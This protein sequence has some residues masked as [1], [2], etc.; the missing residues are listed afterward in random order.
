M[1]K[2]S[3]RHIYKEVD[4][5]NLYIY[6]DTF[7]YICKMFC[8]HIHIHP[9]STSYFLISDWLY[10]SK[11]DI[12]HIFIYGS[13][14]KPSLVVFTAGNAV[15]S[16]FNSSQALKQFQTPPEVTQKTYPLKSVPLDPPHLYCTVFSRATELIG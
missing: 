3:H 1:Y 12:L 5:M 15:M 6:Y 14:R 10:V 9:F 2:H 7:M 16:I 11:G 13:C 4:E 8:D